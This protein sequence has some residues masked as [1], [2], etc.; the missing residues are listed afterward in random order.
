MSLYYIEGNHLKLADEVRDQF[1][2]AHDEYGDGI[3]YSSDTLFVFYDQEGTK[4]FAITPETFKWLSGKF[5]VLKGNL[6]HGIY[7]LGKIDADGIRGCTKSYVWDDKTVYYLNGPV[8]GA[9]PGTFEDLGNYWARDSR[10][11]LF[12]EKLIKEADRK[13]FRIFDDPFA[14]DDKHIFAFPGRI[15]SEHHEDPI[16]LGTGYYKISG[17]IFSGFEEV[18]SADLKTFKTLPIIKPDEKKKILTAGGPKTEEEALSVSGFH[19]YDGKRKYKSTWSTARKE[20]HGTDAALNKSIQ[21]IIVAA[22]GAAALVVGIIFLARGHNMAMCVALVI[23]GIS[24]IVWSS[25]R[26]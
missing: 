23:F 4:T 15:I 25:K 1:V 8:D 18:P 19:A 22:V 7:K 26:K 21:K 6:H 14:V 20:R 9:D 3:A 13:S 24:Q 11:I 10:N 16:P 5:F 12:Q 2:I 17:K